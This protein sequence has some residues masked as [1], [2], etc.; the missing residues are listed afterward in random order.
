LPVA[1]VAATTG[2]PAGDS[3]RPS[4]LEVDPP[5]RSGAEWGRRRRLRAQCFVA[6][7]VMLARESEPLRSHNVAS[8]PWIT[9]LSPHTLHRHGTSFVSNQVRASLVTDQL[10]FQTPLMYVQEKARPAVSEASEL[11]KIGNK[12]LKPFVGVRKPVIKHGDFYFAILICSE[13]TNL[14]FREPLRG[15]IDALIVPEWNPDTNSFASFVES[16]ALDVH[17]YVVQVNNRM[18]GDTRVRGPYREVFKRDVVRTKGGECDYFVVARL[19]VP[20]LREFQSQS[21][22]P[23]DGQFKPV[24]D[25]FVI[26][27]GRRPLP[28]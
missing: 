8:Q 19:D 18:Y 22:S 11:S 27:P 17:C 5:E 1:R 14:T 26:D 7:V 28:W 3:R 23:A 12:S 9:P 25:G 10:G 24:P 2:S 13:L 6:D 20:A 21:P 16:A 4:S 15:R